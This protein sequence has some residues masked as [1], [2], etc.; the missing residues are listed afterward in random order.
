MIIVPAG[1]E[2]Q[3]I[4]T[5]KSQPLELVTVYSPAEHHPQTVHKTKEEGD[6]EEENEID[7]PA[8]WSREYKDVNEEKGLVKGEGGPYG[9]NDDGR[10]NRKID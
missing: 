7:V 9:N 2:H 5:S 10:H 3:F 8:G 6:E 4:N 1:T